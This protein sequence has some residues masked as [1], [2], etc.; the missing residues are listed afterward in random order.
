MSQLYQFYFLDCRTQEVN[1]LLSLML[2]VSQHVFCAYLRPEINHSINL[3]SQ[4]CNNNN[5]CQQHNVKHSD[6]LPEKQISHLS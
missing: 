5:E 1:I 2:S 4:L 3:F 6:G